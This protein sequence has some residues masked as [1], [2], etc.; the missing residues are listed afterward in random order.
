[1]SLFTLFCAGDPRRPYPTDID[2]RS[3]VLARINDTALNQQALSSANTLSE[4]LGHGRQA[5]HLSGRY[6]N[7]Y[8]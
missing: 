3:G 7:F 6:P 8:L 4:V 2:M 5:M 1:M